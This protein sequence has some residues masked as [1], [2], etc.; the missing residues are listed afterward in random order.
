MI[1]PAASISARWE[2]AWGK[3]PQVVDGVG[4]ELLGVQPERR[5]HPQQPLHEVAGPA[6]L[7]H[8]GE[9]GDEPE[10]ADEEGALLARQAVVGLVGAVAQHE[11]ALGEVVGDGEDRGLE[12]GVVAGE[13]AEDGGQQGGG[14]EGVRVVVL[15][16]DAGVADAVGEDVVLDLL[17]GGPPGGVGIA[18]APHG[19]EGGARSSATQHMSLDDT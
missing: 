6:P 7:P 4:V 17:G 18:V 14:V 13:E 11:A 8:D 12:A 5:G 10:R 3:F 9:G 1:R 2:N 15:A 16:Q 19:G